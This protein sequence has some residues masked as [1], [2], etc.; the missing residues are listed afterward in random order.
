MWH[1]MDQ[2]TIVRRGQRVRHIEYGPS[3]VTRVTKDAIWI[4]PDAAGYQ[5][6]TCSVYSLRKLI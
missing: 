4:K 6:G 5:E 3:T 1:R 2:S